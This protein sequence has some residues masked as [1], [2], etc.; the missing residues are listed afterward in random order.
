MILWT[1]S[2]SLE[3]LWLNFFRTLAKVGW[4]QE[5]QG[6]AEQ[7]VSLG[8]ERNGA[9]LRSLALGPWTVVEKLDAQ[10]PDHKSQLRSNCS[11]LSWPLDLKFKKEFPKII[12]QFAHLLNREVI[13]N[14]EVTPWVP[15]H[16]WYSS[17]SKDSLVKPKVLSLSTEGYYHYPLKAKGSQG[18]RV[19][20]DLELNL[21]NLSLKMHSLCCQW[22]PR[23]RICYPS[24]TSE[25]TSSSPLQ[26]MALMSQSDSAT[27]HT[28]KCWVNARMKWK[29]TCQQRGWYDE[30]V[31]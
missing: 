27:E 12:P 15:L 18:I 13:L 11:C 21:R 14:R 31:S 24:E 16:F 25:D 2:S 17:S 10:S 9:R 30:W 5:G 28:D 19:F 6:A 20:P 7:Q 1:F 4:G 26:T 29:S 8:T 22:N 23:S 3:A